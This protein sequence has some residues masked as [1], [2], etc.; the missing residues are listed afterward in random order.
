MQIVTTLMVHLIVLVILAIMGMVHIAKVNISIIIH[1]K[2]DI[3]K[4]SKN[5][6]DIHKLIFGNSIFRITYNLFI[7]K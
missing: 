2:H 3:L 5:Q 4:R 1:S 7:I 6:N